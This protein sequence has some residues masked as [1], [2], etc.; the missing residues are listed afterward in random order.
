M[1]KTLTFL[2]A[3]TLSTQAFAHAGHIAHT[4]GHTHWGEVA[5]VVALAVACIAIIVRTHKTA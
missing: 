5:V 2:T 1:T 3:A 4:A